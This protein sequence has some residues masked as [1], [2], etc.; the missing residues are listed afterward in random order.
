MRFEYHKENWQTLEEGEKDCFLLTNGL[1]GYC[2][3]A[4]TGA[5]A[6]GDHALL[7]AAKKAPNVRW[8]MLTN[9]LEKL[10][11]DG[12]EY[13][14]ASQ[15]MKSGKNYEGFRYLETFVYDEA[16]ENAPQWTFRFHD[17]CI[18]KSI[19][20]VH[21]ENTVA[22]RYV[23]DNPHGKAV[24]LELT[25]LI[26]FTSKKECFDSSASLDR[27]KIEK[28]DKC[29][30]KSGQGQSMDC[31]SGTLEE[32]AYL[33]SDG[34]SRI[35]VTGNAMLQPQQP[36]LFGEMYFSQDAR[37][38]REAYG[39]ALIN[40]SLVYRSGEKIAGSKESGDNADNLYGRDG[41]D[42]ICVIFSTQPYSYSGDLYE[43]LAQ[44][45][46]SRREQLLDKAENIH[47]ELGRQLVLSADAYVVKRDSTNGKSIIAGYPFF[48]DWGRDTMISLAGATMVTG[49]FEECKS[50]LRTFAKYVKNGLL[51]NLFPEG[52][53]NPM[54]NS[55][56]APL[57]FIN[58]V[59]EYMEYA[60]DYGFKEEI[61]PVLEQIVESYQNGTDFHIKMDTDGLISAGAG[62]EQLTWMDVRV[63]DFLPTPRHG[64][65][66]EVN[67]Y[68][69]N[70]LMVMEKLTGKPVYRQ[71]ADKVK[72][73]F[74][75]KFWNE[76]A[77]CLKDVLSGGRDEDQIRCNQIWVL[78]MPFT[79]LE[80]E[81]EALV[82]RK[83]K[84]ELY[85]AAG[86][87][88]LSPEDPDFHEIYIGKMQERDR[89]YHQ[90]TVWAF[91]LGAYY[92][93]CIRYAG[94][95]E[96]PME[97]AQIM[98]EVRNGLEALKPWLREGCAAQ[99]A[100]IYDG[101]A[102]TVSRGCFAQAWSV[103]ELLR[104]VYDYET[105]A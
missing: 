91:P 88:T 89:A 71:L 105:Q 32:S 8:H 21:G 90:G 67:A 80:P 34:D 9:V 50:I 39:D 36:H 46:K 84:D 31:E 35:Y 26:R 79:L 44:R 45:E 47:S 42:G 66:V 83:V 15:R 92:R 63:G 43:Q 60:G 101:G 33:I 82:I 29:L 76:S 61:L 11:V 28:I 52:D 22:L 16:D 12:Q 58:S 75:E 53:E 104:A 69:Y 37:D 23:V 100:E 56:D 6:R 85:T 3:L 74:G 51:P 98:E 48:E 20:M 1:G 97:K 54:Y 59:Y 62:L 99:M 41:K 70:A 78:T 86:L 4:V 49:R 94:K 102:P 10:T 57:L 96:D 95:C 5:A 87:R 65:P 93:A 81:K 2:S 73:S 64:K 103:A 19:L 68:W 38:G 55:V 17:V 30:S 77:Q 25:P 13:L 24:S 27:I 14:L 40:H 18:Q 72:K 7:M